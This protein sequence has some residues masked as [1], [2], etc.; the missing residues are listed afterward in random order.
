MIHQ[1]RKRIH[2]TA[3]TLRAALRRWLR[4]ATLLLLV[5]IFALAEPLICIIHCQLAMPA[6]AHQHH[7]HSA[8]AH[9]AAG[10]TH[11]QAGSAA[12][13]PQAQSGVGTPWCFANLS[14]AG[15]AP[16]QFVPSS[17]VHK[18][19]LATALALLPFMLSFWI[20]AHPTP[21]MSGRATIPPTPPPRQ[22][23]F[24]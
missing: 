13:E 10:G 8:M 16:D 14:P 4:P 17:P 12:F 6:Q 20:A 21:T 2:A 15:S 5:V 23:I 3:A 7:Q 1:A 22:Q 18:V 9:A 19:V 24:A 11:A